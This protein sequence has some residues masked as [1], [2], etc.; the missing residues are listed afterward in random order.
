M[1]E[2]VPYKSNSKSETIDLSNKFNASLFRKIDKNN[3]RSKDY[4]I[5]SVTA[6]TILVSLF[7]IYYLQHDFEEL[8]LSRTK[9]IWGQLLLVLSYSLLIYQIIFIFYIIY[10]FS[11]YKPI[12]SVSDTELPTC[13]V[14]VPAYNEGKL[15]LETLRSLVANDYPKEKLQIMAIDDGSKDDTWKWMVEAKKELGDRIE[16]LQQPKNMGKRHALYR[17]F[18]TGTGDVFVTVD[19]D[20]IV[21]QDTLRNLVSP[22]VTNKNC[23]AVGGNVR[24]LNKKQGLIPKMLNVTFVFSF[25][26]IRSAQSVSGSVLCTPGALAAYKRT[27]VLSCLESW[28]NQT[29]MGKASDIGEDRALT[30]MILKQGLHVLFQSNSFVYTNSPENYNQLNKMF[31][32]WERSNVR[33]NIEMTK[34]AFSN[35]RE[36]RKFDARFLLINQWIK[37]I[38]S[39]PFTLLMFYLIIS[40]PILFLSSTFFGIFIFSTVQ[41]V[42]YSKKYNFLESL[43]FYT[44]SIFYT[45]TLFWI[46]PYAIITAGKKGWLTREITN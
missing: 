43:W 20:S 14:I 13:T 16:I 45:F 7:L 25:E 23:G 33:E 34:F 18:T 21:K 29:F 12:E 46:T 10:K 19:S 44:Y 15:V 5:F 36:E 1:L 32:R 35:F 17:G 39:I 24:V 31:I 2:N 9:T 28:I 30:N 8:H 22:F 38:L 3:F 42:L 37:V 40:N 41:V 4:F 6:F 26:F 11:K 27:A